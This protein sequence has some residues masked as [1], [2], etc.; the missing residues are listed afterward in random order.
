M[1]LFNDFNGIVSENW[2]FCRKK[3]A[4]LLQKNGGL[5]ADNWRVYCRKMVVAAES[6]GVLDH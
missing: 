4:V 1:E 5:I 2:R 6:A 3:L